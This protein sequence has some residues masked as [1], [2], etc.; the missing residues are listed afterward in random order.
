MTTR[1]HDALFKS[2]F[3]AP[4]DAAALLRELLP[5]AVQAMVAWKTLGREHGSFVDAMLADH[6][7][8]LL[9]SAQLRTDAS[10]VVNFLL[11]HQS[12]IDPTMS[13][14]ALSYQVRIWNRFVKEHPDAWLPPVF[15]V[16]LSHARAGWTAPRAFEDLF[17]PAV[18][19]LSGIGPLVPRFSMIVDDLIHLSND[20]LSARPLGPFQKLALWLLRDARDPLHPLA[21]FEF[22]TPSML[23]LGRTPPGLERLN[24]LITYMFQVIDPMHLDELHAK[25]RQL[26][27]R[28]EEIAMTIAEYLHEKGRREGRIATLRNLLVFKFQTLSAEDEARLQAAAPET[29]DRYFQR[30]LT[31][32]SLADVFED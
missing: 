3:E 8:D 31:A 32:D 15:A 20:G 27:S 2:A 4:A 12:T 19:S 25:L 23:E 11:E 10:Q 17:H 5:P 14:R 1:P 29:I 28:T 26:G 30:L 21:S 6:H 22:W 18:I 24:V 16:L 9:F 13:L 7:S